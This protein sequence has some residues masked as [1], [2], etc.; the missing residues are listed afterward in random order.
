MCSFIVKEA[1][2]FVKF[3]H[4]SPKKDFGGSIVPGAIHPLKFDSFPLI[5]QVDISD[6]DVVDDDDYQLLTSIYAK[7]REW[8]G[9]LEDL[10]KFVT[11]PYRNKVVE[12][13]DRAKQFTSKLDRII[14]LANQ[15]TCSYLEKLE[16]LR[17]QKERAVA[18]KAGLLGLCEDEAPVI[19]QVMPSSDR[20]QVITRTVTKFRLT[21]LSKVP[22][23]YLTIDERA[24]EKDIRLGVLSIPGIEIYE[25]TTTSLRRTS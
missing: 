4:S 16:K 22:L 20:A 24:I 18:E 19:H 14:E 3:L 25:E 11:Q 17:Q 5:E 9:A 21:D 13:N 2:T 6:L 7:A 8:K 10:R 15:K 1:D 23:Q 12:I